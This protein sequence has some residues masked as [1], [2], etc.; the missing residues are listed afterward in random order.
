MF[1]IVATAAAAF[2][3]WQERRRAAAQLASMDD[4]LLADIGVRRTEIPFVIRGTAQSRPA[5]NDQTRYAA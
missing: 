4:R 3:A 1:S 5:A 2:R